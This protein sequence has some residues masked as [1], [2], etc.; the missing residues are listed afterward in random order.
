MQLSA[1]LILILIISNTEF[2]N[3][4]KDKKIGQSEN[5]VTN[6]HR[7]IVQQSDGK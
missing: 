5:L 1:C 2:L 6:C 7:T 4:I 3:F